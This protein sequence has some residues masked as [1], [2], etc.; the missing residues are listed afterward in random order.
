MVA[1]RVGNGGPG[2]AGTTGCRSSVCRVSPGS[3][4][5]FRP[6]SPTREPGLWPRLP[7][8]SSAS[9]RLL[10]GGGVG[11]EVSVLRG[12]TGTNVAG[13]RRGPAAP[14]LGGRGARPGPSVLLCP[15][16]RGCRRPDRCGRTAVHLLC[17]GPAESLIRCLDWLEH[18][19]W[20]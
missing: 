10:A 5:V 17:F 15:A 14:G 3:H 1:P 16:R 18:L 8:T 20:L 13:R 2:T 7:S 12:R 19:Q 6:E 11:R 9:S 4:T